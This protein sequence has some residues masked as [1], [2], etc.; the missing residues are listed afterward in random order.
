MDGG[1]TL[2]ARLPGRDSV[3]WMCGA[4]VVHVLYI[5]YMLHP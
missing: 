2:E 3:V 5:L 1:E 4:I